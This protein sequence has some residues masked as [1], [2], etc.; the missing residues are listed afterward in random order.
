MHG[1][2]RNLESVDSTMT[3]RGPR[4]KLKL[5]CAYIDSN[6][7]DCNTHPSAVSCSNSQLNETCRSVASASKRDE[8]DRCQPS[9]PAFLTD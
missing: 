8:G 6:P 4:L 9:L 2:I 5:R 7:G 3:P 1:A